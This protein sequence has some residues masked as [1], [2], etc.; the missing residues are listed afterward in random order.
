MGRYRAEMFL[1]ARVRSRAPRRRVKTSRSTRSKKSQ[2]VVVRDDARDERFDDKSAPAVQRRNSRGVDRVRAR[3]LPVRTSARGALAQ[4]RAGGPRRGGAARLRAGR[5]R[6]SRFRFAARGGASSGRRRRPGA[7][8]FV[9]GARRAARRAPTSGR[10]RSPRAHGEAHG[11]PRARRSPR[12]KG[13]RRRRR[14]RRRRRHRFSRSAFPNGR[15]EKNGFSS[16]D[17]T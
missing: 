17:K 2:V 11:A 12:R 16:N 6:L 9:R 15:D 5:R 3:S 1:G 4:T 8:A 14:R 13:A 7:R 10:E